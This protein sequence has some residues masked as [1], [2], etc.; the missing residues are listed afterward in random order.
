MLI[1]G[2]EVF[3]TEQ[4]TSKI[5][6]DINKTDLL[7]DQLKTE[8]DMKKAKELASEFPDFELN[9]FFDDSKFGEDFKTRN[10]KE[11]YDIYREMVES[12]FIHRGLELIADD[13]TQPN[14]D[15][16]VLEVITN[17]EEI[18]DTLEDLFI[19]RLDLNNEL[20]SMFYETGKLGDN[21]YEV[22][23]DD[24]KK[25]KEISKV[26]FLKPEKTERVEINDKLSYFTYKTEKRDKKGNKLEEQLFKLWPW[27][28][29]HF[30]IEDKEN[31]PYGGS[32]L[33]SGAKTFKRLSLLEDIMLVYRISRAPERRVFYIDVGNLTPV[34]ARQFLNKM[35]NSYRSNSIID[36]NGNLNK[37]SN[38][39]SITS[40]IFIPVREGSQGTRIDTLQPGQ[41]MGA[42]GSEDP[43]LS[44]FKNKILKTMNIPPAYLGEESDRSRNLCLHP[45]TKIKLADGRS[46]SIKQLTEEYKNGK[47]NYVYSIDKNNEWVI[48]P[49]AW[50]GETRKDAELIEITLDNNE[51]VICTPDHPFML[52]DG[53]Y[54]QAKDL[55]ENESL[56]PIY[57]K[58]SSDKEKIAGYEMLLNNNTGE[59]VYTHRIAK[60]EEIN[61]EFEKDIHYSEK[62]TTIHHKDFNKLNNNPDNLECM[63]NKA[64]WK[65]HQELGKNLSDS[66]IIKKRNKSIKKFY[67][68]NIEYA[69]EKM[70]HARNSKA[71]KEWL[72]SEEHKKLKRKQIAKQREEGNIKFTEKIREKLSGKNNYQYRP[73]LELSNI[74]KI[75]DENHTTNMSFVARILGCATTSIRNKVIKAGYSSFKEFANSPNNHKVKSIKYLSE[76]SNM[77]DITIDEETPNFALDIGVIVH[78][79]QLDTKFGRF[80]ERVQAQII[81]TLNKIAALELFFKGY[82]KEELNNFQIQLTA[83][84]NIKEVTEIDIISQKM[85]LIATIQ[86]LQLFPNQWILKKVLKLSDKEISDIMFQKTMEAQAGAGAQEGGAEAGGLEAGF[87]GAPEAGGEEGETPPEAEAPEEITA[88]A[89]INVLGQDFL[90]E[91]K[92]DMFKLFK[93][94]QEENEPDKLPQLLESIGNYLNTDLEPPKKQSK[95]NVKHL[96]IENEFGGLDLDKFS[97]NLYK[98]QKDNTDETLTEEFI[99][100]KLTFSNGRKDNE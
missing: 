67:N 35:K 45:E 48:K 31:D 24:Y 98:K 94:I 51:K 83:P 6:T 99:V 93:K 44:Y 96:I 58:T 87:G 52:K 55:K 34:E 78:N 50:A 86:A 4:Q 53:S 3:Y 60:Q 36:E 23:P 54:K 56:M 32:L 82:K 38:V 92:E 42:T 57:T 90:I 19:R 40:D 13:S 33:E 72:S 28:I 64:H 68:D 39:L 20:W 21:F 69:R 41:A 73:E 30:K 43:L 1:N 17:D 26:R 95:N 59:W 66:E 77:Y 88:S 15:G 62:R 29:A 71:C 76:R 27:Q 75:T 5:Q 25:P 91:N 74:K 63:T 11:R 70:N 47:T 61:E 8:V 97:F 7:D 37:K 16:N 10:R 79:S 12:E 100:T 65:L 9:T 85:N 49:I 81:R 84:S 14:E 46:I 18:K 89:I 22:I 80:I 2:K